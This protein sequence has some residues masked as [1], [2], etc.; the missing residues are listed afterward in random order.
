MRFRYNLRSNS[1]DQNMKQCKY[2]T[3]SFLRVHIAI[4]HRLWGECHKDLKRLVNELRFLMCRKTRHYQ[5]SVTLLNVLVHLN[6][7]GAPQY[8]QHIG[9]QCKL[10]DL[11]TLS[12]FSHL[13]TWL[14]YTGFVH[15]PMM[16]IWWLLQKAVESCWEYTYLAYLDVGLYCWKSRNWKAKWQVTFSTELTGETPVPVAS[17]FV[18]CTPYANKGLVIS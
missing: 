16:W 7:E 12:N 1:L 3:V 17:L 10:I 5:R 15:H 18:F 14:P 9:F 2:P 11:L 4:S 13:R 6:F 8:C